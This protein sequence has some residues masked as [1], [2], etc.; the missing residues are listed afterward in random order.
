MTA[1]PGLTDVTPLPT[2]S[3]HPAFSWPRIYGSNVPWESIALRHTPSMICRSV[4]HRP[5]APTRTMTSS[6]AVMVGTGTLS[7][8]R[9][10]CMCSSYAYSRAAFIMRVPLLRL[11]QRGGTPHRFTGQEPYGLHAQGM[12]GRDAARSDASYP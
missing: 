6:A 2:S 8:V 11:L 3:T 1:S 9:S 12:F 5:A 10:T 7:S 4:R